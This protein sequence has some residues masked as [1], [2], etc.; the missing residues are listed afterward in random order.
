MPLSTLLVEGDLD[1]QL[2]TAVFGGHPLVQRGG[3]KNSLAPEVRRLR[4]ANKG[5]VGINAAYLRDR[6]FDFDPPGDCSCPTVD[7]EDSDKVLGWRWCWHEIE[8]YLLEPTIVCSAIECDRVEYELA[9][10]ESAKHLRHY[11]IARWAI[12]IARRGLPPQYELATRPSELNEIGIPD[13]LSSE[14][15]FQWGRQQIGD[16]YQ[17]VQVSLSSDAV[18]NSLVTLDASWTEAALSDV[19][20]V[21]KMFS[22]KDLMAGIADWWRSKN[23]NNAG[24]FRATLRDW[25][26]D[27][28]DEALAA[29]DEWQQLKEIVSQ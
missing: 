1:V 18:N 21:L 9:L 28:V 12:G 10:T 5:I 20:F 26:I 11:E 29:L 23:F 24:E 15:S 13:D 16:F 27:H 4:R 22:G 25:F 3:S 14:A 7:R 2:L 6:D 17:R 8:N 19:S